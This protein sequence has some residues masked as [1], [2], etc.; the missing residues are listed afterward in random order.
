[1]PFLPSSRILGN[2]CSK[3]TQTL[4][5]ALFCRFFVLLRY[6][7][8]LIVLIASRKRH[9]D[10]SRPTRIHH[11]ASR[12]IFGRSI[13]QEVS[14]KTRW[15]SCINIHYSRFTRAT[16]WSLCKR[17]SLSLSLSL[18]RCFPVPRRGLQLHSLDEKALCT[19]DRGARITCSS[20]PGFSHRSYFH[21][22]WSFEVLQ[23]VSWFV[24]ADAASK[25]QTVVL[26]IRPT[27]RWSVCSTRS[28]S[29]SSKLAL[30]RGTRV[31]PLWLWPGVRCPEFRQWSVENWDFL[32]TVKKWNSLHESLL[33]YRTLIIWA[34]RRNVG[35]FLNFSRLILTFRDA[36]LVKM[37]RCWL[38][39]YYRYKI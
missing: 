30:F 35:I 16:R 14:H 13:F 34:R 9:L 32:F 15:P 22:R 37:L 10:P 18:S 36:K 20:R 11:S 31:S 24:L 4:L 25:L 23:G 2:C 39:T 38:V 21:E 19:Q 33:F 28:I 5:T 26:R 17:S 29:A 6:T 12:L 27:R 1:M 7:P 3:I 8:P